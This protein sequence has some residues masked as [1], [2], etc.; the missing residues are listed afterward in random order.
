MRYLALGFTEQLVLPASNNDLRIFLPGNPGGS[1]GFVDSAR[2]RFKFDVCD[3]N[4][5]GG[6]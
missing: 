1:L 5:F 2:L 6:S 4:V 3:S